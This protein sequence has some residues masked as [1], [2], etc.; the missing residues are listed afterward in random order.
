MR[1]SCD[2]ITLEEGRQ[3]PHSPPNPPAVSDLTLNVG[4]QEPA[5]RG[6]K[7]EGHS[8]VLPLSYPRELLS[9]ARVERDDFL[10]SAVNGSNTAWRS[11]DDTCEVADLCS[12]DEHVMW[13]GVLDAVLPALSPSETHEHKLT[14]L[15]TSPGTYTVQIY[16]T[17]SIDKERG[18][19]LATEQR[20]TLGDIH[21]R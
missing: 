20:I 15:F 19:V 18:D 12:G 17:T 5:E 10:P 1:L 4:R 9:E 21:H 2:D 14:A 11:C 7:G 16:C 13:V 8:D 6:F 3:E